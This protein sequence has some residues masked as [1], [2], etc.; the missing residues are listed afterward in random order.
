[1][2]IFR[3]QRESD[4][5][6]D[7]ADGLMPEERPGILFRP[8]TD[9]RWLLGTGPNL[10]PREIESLEET[11]RFSLRGSRTQ[12]PASHFLPRVTTSYQMKMAAEWR[13]D[14][15]VVTLFRK[16]DVIPMVLLLR[17][18]KHLSESERV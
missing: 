11:L 4:G 3:F 16:Y 18:S 7:S 8:R 5:Q 13:R 12:I 2:T 6:G 17:T 15:L 1:M 10:S 14:C 9:A